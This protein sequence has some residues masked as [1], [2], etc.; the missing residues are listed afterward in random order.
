MLF[1]SGWQLGSGLGI[2]SSW[3]TA[4][5][6]LFTSESAAPT[7][8]SLV[9]ENRTRG[10]EFENKVLEAEGLD[11][12]RGPSVRQEG[13]AAFKPDSLSPS[14]LAEVKSQAYIYK[15]P[16]LQAEVQFA[17]DTNRA[18]RLYVDASKNPVLS[19]PLMDMITG[20]GGEVVRW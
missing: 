10:L 14:T 16:Q 5:K 6:K 12:Y 17:E 3:G 7:K 19:A 15:T 20:A 11:K 18:F 1:R 13:Q 9:Q 8:Q 4:V 2:L